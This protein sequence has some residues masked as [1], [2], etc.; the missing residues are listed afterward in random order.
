MENR[1]ILGVRGERVG[2]WFFFKQ[3]VKC[4]TTFL[5]LHPQNLF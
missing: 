5:K 2:C 1:A 3:I 4:Q